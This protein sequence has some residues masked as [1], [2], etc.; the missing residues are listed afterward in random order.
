MCPTEKENT[1]LVAHTAA[2]ISAPRS[3]AASNGATG[4][5]GAAIIQRRVAIRSVLTAPAA[6]AGSAMLAAA[7]SASGAPSAGGAA[8]QRPDLRPNVTVGF[9]QT[10]GQ[11]EQ[12]LVNQVVDRW[13]QA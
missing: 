3:R 4:A 11:V 6:L 9:L 8:A 1:S 10:S 13:K 12:N 7:C 2:S 5:Y